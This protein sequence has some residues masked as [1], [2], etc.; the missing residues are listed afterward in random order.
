MT[1]QH[2]NFGAWADAREDKLQIA[3]AGWSDVPF[4]EKN[5]KT[6]GKRRNYYRLVQADHLGQEKILRII[7]KKR[8]QVS[9]YLGKL[10]LSFNMAARRTA[11]FFSMKKDHFFSGGEGNMLSERTQDSWTAVALLQS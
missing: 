11:N 7:T 4:E 6:R 10:L 5:M 8:K 3:W 1:S 9:I 2:A